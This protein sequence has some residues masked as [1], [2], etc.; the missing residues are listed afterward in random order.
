MSYDLLVLTPDGPGGP[1]V[2]ERVRTVLDSMRSAL[3]DPPAEPDARIAAFHDEITGLFPDAG[4]DDADADGGEQAE[5][6][7]SIS[8]QI[9]APDW[10]YLCITWSRAEE[11]HHAVDRLA[12]THG[13]AVFNPQSGVVVQLRSTPTLRASTEN[14]DT[15]DD[16]SSDALL[17]LFEGIEEGTSSYLIVDDLADATGHTYA[18]T[19]RNKD[20]S[21]VVEHRD[22]SPDRHFGT[23]APDMASAHALIAGWAQQAPGW[24]ESA[25]WEQVSF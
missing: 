13:L 11:L 17:M 10:L 23:T 18:Q 12:A 20:G 14:G 24:R 8:P 1:R 2:F 15:I 6:P 3:V 16:P 7:W 5:V 25:T 9:Q 4:D 22:G 19:S 21:W